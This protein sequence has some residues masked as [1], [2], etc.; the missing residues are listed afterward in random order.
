MV[1]S[2]TLIA[3]SAI[4]VGF[5]VPAVCV[6]STIYYGFNFIMAGILA[7]IALLTAGAITVVGIVLG[8]LAQSFEGPSISE[9]EKLGAMRAHQRATLEELDDIIDVL[10]EIRDALKAAE[11]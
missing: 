8:P 9:R 6:Y 4:A 10:K 11:E 1:K 7:A 5:G 2:A 3:L